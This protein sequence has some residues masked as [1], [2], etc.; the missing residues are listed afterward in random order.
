MATPVSLEIRGAPNVGENDFS[1]EEIIKAFTVANPFGQVMRAVP[2]AT[3]HATFTGPAASNYSFCI[4]IPD[5]AYPGTYNL[6]GVNV[7]DVGTRCSGPSIFPCS[8]TAPSFGWSVDTI[9]FEFT[10]LFL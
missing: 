5:P 1:L 2:L 8:A 4:I 6:H 9:G 7:G 10:F 3:G